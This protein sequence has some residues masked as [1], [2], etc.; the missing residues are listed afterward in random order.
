MR[1]A[2][3]LALLATSAQ[4]DIVLR[5]EDGN[6]H[7]RLW[8]RNTDQCGA[9]TGVLQIDFEPSAGRVLLDTEYG[10]LGTKDPMPVEVELGNIRLAPVTDG[11]R[12]LTVFLEGLG[13]GDTAVVTMD[14]DNEASF[15][16]SPRVEVF[17]GHIE[18]TIA[19]FTDTD[20]TPQAIF[21]NRAIARISLAEQPC[22]KEEPPALTVPLS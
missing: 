2:G 15:W 20:V 10:G 6:P 1:W 12:H 22:P 9:I 17:G 16:S 11:D 4:A 19:R 21:D 3:L 14:F 18:G 7:D 13:A 5:M 8:I